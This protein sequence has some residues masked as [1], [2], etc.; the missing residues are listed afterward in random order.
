MFEGD[1][2]RT[3]KNEISQLQL[4]LQK[5]F[6]KTIRDLKP[7][8]ERLVEAWSEKQRVVESP[9]ITLSLGSFT[10]IIMAVIGASVF[11]TYFKVL[12]GSAFAFLMG[13]IVGYLV[14]TA[15]II[16]DKE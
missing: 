4:E 1:V 12:D 16:T 2:L 7:V 8:F 11:L 14:S 13:T 15:K 5:D 3:K 9:K 6:Y 10:L